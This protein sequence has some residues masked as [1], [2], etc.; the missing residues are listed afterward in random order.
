MNEG[1]TNASDNLSG[2]VKLKHLFEEYYLRLC[3]F[4]NKMIDSRETSED[5]VQDAFVALWGEKTGFKDENHAK[6]YLYLTVKNACLNHLRHNEVTKRFAESQNSS[7]VEEEK[8]SQNII[9]AELTGQIHSAIASLPK[10]CGQVL[11]L[12]YFDGLKNKEI[13]NHL[14]ISVNTVKT[15]KARALQLLRMKLDVEELMVI[16]AVIHL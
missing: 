10:G 13:A 11:T 14:R 5:I 16:L 1:L 3:Y 12:A 6:N 15:Q 7:E 4:A 8:I 9:R 2:S